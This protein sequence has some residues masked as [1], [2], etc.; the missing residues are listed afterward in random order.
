MMVKSSLAAWEIA[1]IATLDWVSALEFI[2]A[3]IMLFASKGQVGFLLSTIEVL[4]MMKD[5]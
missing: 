1:G 2:T 4:W 3:M 5:V